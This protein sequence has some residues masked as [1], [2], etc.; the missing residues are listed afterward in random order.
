VNEQVIAAEG[1]R[2][3]FDASEVLGG[4]SLAAGEGEVV[5]I[6]GAAARARARSCAALRY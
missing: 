6:I 1:L 2:K 4:V 5:A 3:R